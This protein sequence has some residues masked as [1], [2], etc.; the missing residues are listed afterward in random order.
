M[1]IVELSD[2]P[3]VMLRKEHERQRTA[4]EKARSRYAAELALHQGR[5]RE[6]RARR[7][8]ARVQRRWLTWLRAAFAVRREQARAP[9]PPVV[10]GWP[11]GQEEILTAGRTGEQRVASDLS[12]VL[13]DAWVLFRGYRNRG[14]EIDH[15]LVGPRGIFAMEGK[16]RNATVH[17]DGD[18]WRYD[19]YDRY[20]NLV[21]QGEIADR[22]GRSPSMQVNQPADELEK[23]LRSRGQE[24]AIRRIVVLTHDKSQLG[25]CRNQTVSVT[26]ST[27]HV[28]AMVRESPT[29]LATGP[30]TEIERL[31]RQDHRFH[32]TR[33]RR[34]R[35]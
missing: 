10:P 19:K 6:A 4:E 13:D 7:E 33:A 31:I 28:L 32:E 26:S 35:N 5:V 21:E 1:R 14:G 30:A 17:V 3:A 15:L 25:T 20:G 22:G 8:E 18:H 2:H 11:S 24:V 12:R 34:S 9:R 23:F 16:H 29:E 27:S